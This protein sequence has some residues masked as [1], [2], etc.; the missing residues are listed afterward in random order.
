MT[1]QKSL[2]KLFHF[3]MPVQ[4]IHVVREP[5]ATVQFKNLGITVHFLQISA[6]SSVRSTLGQV[7]DSS[8][9]CFDRIGPQK[10]RNIM[11]NALLHARQQQLLLSHNRR[12]SPSKATFPGK[13][14]AT[15]VLFGH[16]FVR[17]CL[18]QWQQLTPWF[19]LKRAQT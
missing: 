2:I 6:S 9:A 15:V 13:F 7:F 16:L 12:P 18:Q 17:P 5:A 4:T 11:S 8:P 19:A 14:F 10:T 3:W 1:A